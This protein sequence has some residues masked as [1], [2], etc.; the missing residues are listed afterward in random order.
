MDGFW[1]YWSDSKAELN[2]YRFVQ[3]RYGQLREGRAVL[4]FVTEPF[5]RSKKVKVDRYDR[6]NPDHTMV[7]NLNDVRKFQT[8]VYD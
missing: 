8:G 1:R 3:P 5:S 4:V 7:L 6:N 2:G